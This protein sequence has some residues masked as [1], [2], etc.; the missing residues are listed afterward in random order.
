[1]YSKPI[2]LAAAAS[3]SSSAWVSVIECCT[4]TGQALAP[5]IVYI[6]TELRTSWFKD[7]S[8]MELGWKYDFSESGWSN[9]EIAI[10]WL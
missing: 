5:P 1:M 8:Q 2:G 10:K 9:S 6:G 4:A 3:S 7:P